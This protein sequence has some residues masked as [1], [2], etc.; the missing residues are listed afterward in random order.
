MVSEP[1]GPRHTSKFPTEHAEAAPSTLFQLARKPAHCAGPAPCCAACPC[2]HPRRRS[3]LRC[4]WPAPAGAPPAHDLPLQ[5][6]ALLIRCSQHQLGAWSIGRACTGMTPWPG[7]THEWSLRTAAQMLHMFVVSK[8]CSNSIPRLFLSA[9][10]MA[11]CCQAAML[12]SKPMTTCH[13]PEEDVLALAG[14]ACRTLNSDS[15]FR[16]SRVKPRTFPCQN[17][18][19]TLFVP[20]IH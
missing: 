19:I 10:P 16:Q 20:S 9:S 1:G 6:Q 3:P 18:T 14:H 4:C 15:R 17:A 5:G 7:D 13:P 12:I 8:V 2:C 11:E